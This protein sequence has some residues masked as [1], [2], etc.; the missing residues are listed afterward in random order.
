[1]IPWEGKR[2]EPQ[3]ENRPVLAIHKPS[4]TSRQAYLSAGKCCGNRISAGDARGADGRNGP[5][6]S[7]LAKGR[8]RSLTHQ[9]G[10]TRPGRP[11]YGSIRPAGETELQGKGRFEVQVAAYRERSQAEQ[12][13]EENSGNGIFVPGGDEGTSREREMVSRDRGRFRESGKGAR[14]G[15]ADDREDSRIEI[16]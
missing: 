9:P 3:R 11:G 5:S 7:R 12:T 10:G 15:R 2:G 13:G 1:M 6:G 14:G 16:A 8:E 4:D